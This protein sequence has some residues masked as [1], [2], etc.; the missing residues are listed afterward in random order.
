M[1]APEVPGEPMGER[2]GGPVYPRPSLLGPRQIRG[3]RFGRTRF[4]RRGL[5]PDQVRR[6]LARVAEEVAVLQAEVDRVRQESGRLRAVL[7]EWQTRYGNQRPSYGGRHP[8][9]SGRHES[10]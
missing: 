1:P 4:G 6:F 5:D 9:Q 8:Q 10:V 2:C 7:R 3:A